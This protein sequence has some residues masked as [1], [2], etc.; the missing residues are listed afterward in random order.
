MDVYVELAKNSLEEFIKHGKRYEPPY[1]PPLPGELTS[2]RA[3]VFVSLKKDGALRGCIGSLQPTMENIVQEIV[4]YA[5]LAGSKDP[6]FPPVDVAELDSIEYSVDVLSTPEPTTFD[7]LD[8]KEYGVIVTN[9]WRRGVLLPNLE[10]VDT[11][12]EQISI[13]MQ[14]AHIRADEPYELER[15]RVVRHK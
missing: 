6:R 8:A 11:P 4:E 12:E 1:D 5:I 15:F 7:E 9:G 13:A 10:D 3:A 2:Q 14:K